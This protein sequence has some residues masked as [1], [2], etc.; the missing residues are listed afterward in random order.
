M[1]ELGVFAV[2]Y[3]HLAGAC[4]FGRFQRGRMS[5]FAH[6]VRD[7]HIPRQNGALRISVHSRCDAHAGLVATCVHQNHTFK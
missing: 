4:T 6:N 3:P 5:A 1:L 2:E 7:A